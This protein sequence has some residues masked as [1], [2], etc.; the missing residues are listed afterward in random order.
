[1][2]FSGW[3]RLPTPFRTFRESISISTY[4]VA[5]ISGPT[6][7]ILRYAALLSSQPSGSFLLARFNEIPIYTATLPTRAIA[8]FYQR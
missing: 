5:F 1:M 6:T 3:T 4:S 8:G 7:N 2:T